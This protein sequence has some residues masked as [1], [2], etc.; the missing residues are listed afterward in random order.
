MTKDPAR[1]GDDLEVRIDPDTCRC[2]VDI[3]LAVMG[4]LAS[5]TA[6]HRPRV[7]VMR[8]WVT[9]EGT[10]ERQDQIGSTEDAVLHVPGV[11]GVT[12]RMR[13]PGSDAPDDALIDERE[14]SLVRE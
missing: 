8:G 3:A 6:K 4:A 9:L 13:I 2:D 1:V 11:R 5:S 7:S 14:A 10:A 12:N